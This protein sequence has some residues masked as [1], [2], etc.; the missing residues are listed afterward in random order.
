MAAQAVRAPARRAAAALAWVV[1][2][3]L[4][5]QAAAH[6]ATWLGIEVTGDPAVSAGG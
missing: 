3:A 5:A 6:K 1:L 4:A 2:A